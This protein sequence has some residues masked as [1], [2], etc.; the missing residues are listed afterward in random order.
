MA[1]YLSL[2]FVVLQWLQATPPD[3][4]VVVKGTGSA[5]ATT[6]VGG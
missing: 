4:P 3:K 1:A 2:A 5:L 6:P